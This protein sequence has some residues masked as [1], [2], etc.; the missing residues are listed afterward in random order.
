MTIGWIN[1]SRMPA[2]RTTFSENPGMSKNIRRYGVDGSKS[3][4]P[5]AST[6][7]NHIEKIDRD[8]NSVAP[9][10]TPR[11]RGHIG[12]HRTEVVGHA[13]GGSRRWLP[14]TH[15]KEL[16]GGAV[17]THPRLEPQGQAHSAS[18][19]KFGKQSKVP[20]EKREQH[21]RRAPGAV[22]DGPIKP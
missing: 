2:N 4:F 22:L 8:R 13:P 6:G 9:S 18:G 16:I 17:Q 14:P 12:P 19:G 10:L 11:T 5:H 1:K 21:M 7:E 20:T 15:D 3:D